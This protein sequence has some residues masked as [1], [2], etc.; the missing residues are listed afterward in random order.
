MQAFVMFFVVVATLVSNGVYSLPAINFT[1]TELPNQILK[2]LSEAP[3][4]HLAQQQQES[5]RVDPRGKLKSDK[6]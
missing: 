4:A 6:L 5:V 1:D 3:L 2:T